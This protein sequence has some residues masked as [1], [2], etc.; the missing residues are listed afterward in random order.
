MCHVRGGVNS[1][2]QRGIPINSVGS[3]KG[4]AGQ[5]PLPPTWNYIVCLG[6]CVFSASKYWIPHLMLWI[7]VRCDTSGGKSFKTS[8]NCRVNEEQAKTVL[9]AI[10]SYLWGLL[11]LSENLRVTGICRSGKWRTIKKRGME[12]AGLENDGVKQEQ[13]YILHPIKNF[14]VYDM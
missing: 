4:Q 2:S 11:S 8:Y 9:S 7:T 14:S 6:P 12:F 3:T 5:W 13:T 10:S 1:A